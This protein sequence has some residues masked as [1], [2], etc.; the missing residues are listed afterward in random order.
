MS[1][2][3]KHFLM[4]DNNFVKRRKKN[5][6]WYRQSEALTITPPQRDYEIG[7]I[8]FYINQ[9]YFITIIGIHLAKELNQIYL[10][11]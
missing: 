11:I 8:K 2:N 3:Q 5:R 1:A 7:R 10:S 9:L 4:M 6:C